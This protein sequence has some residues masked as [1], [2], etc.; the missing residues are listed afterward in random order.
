MMVSL[1]IIDVSHLPLD[2]E[3]ESGERAG[4][5]NLGDTQGF[6]VDGFVINSPEACRIK[7]QVSVWRFAPPNEDDRLESELCER[8]KS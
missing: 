6:G 3:R 4:G 7:H 1:W 5:T 2:A 8:D